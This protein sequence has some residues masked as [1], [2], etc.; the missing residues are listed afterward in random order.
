[1]KNASMRAKQIVHELRQAAKGNARCVTCNYDPNKC[2]KTG[3][4]LMRKA[5]NEI[6]YL[7]IL[8]AQASE[9]TAENV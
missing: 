1:M 8:V 7:S 6:E 4:I 3:C 5:A 9:G 2:E